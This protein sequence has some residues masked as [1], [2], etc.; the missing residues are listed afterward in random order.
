[1]RIM[2]ACAL[3]RAAAADRRRLHQATARSS[4]GSCSRTSSSS[5]SSSSSRNSSYSNRGEKKRPQRSPSLELLQRGTARIRALLR[6]GRS[7]RKE[8][9]VADSPAAAALAPSARIAASPAAAAGVAGP[10]LLSS[11]RSEERRVGKECRSRWS[12]YH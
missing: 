5:S 9:A 10:I 6:R 7:R 8:A 1:M 11:N 12:P 4:N 3:S 2:A